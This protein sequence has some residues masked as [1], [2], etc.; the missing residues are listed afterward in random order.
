MGVL[1]APQAEAANAAIVPLALD[2]G[3][4]RM[5]ARRAA[6]RPQRLRRAYPPGEGRSIDRDAMRRNA[7]TIDAYLAG[8]AGEQRSALEALRSAIRSIVPQAEECISYG[9]PA[10]RVG[11]RVVCGFA[12][13]S[14]GCS[15]YPFSGR[16]LGTLAAELEGWSR[17]R[18]ALHFAPGRPPSRALLRKLLRARI[19]EIQGDASERVRRARRST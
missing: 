19:A 9:M 11:G 14:T 6:T 2:P 5:G 3:R 8:L 15:Y 12:A 7:T 10:F 16:T 18:S 4:R 17:T 13:T 1:P